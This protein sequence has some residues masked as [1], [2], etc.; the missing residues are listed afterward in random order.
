MFCVSRFHVRRMEG[1]DGLKELNSIKPMG[2]IM[3]EVEHNKGA[4]HKWYKKNTHTHT[5]KKVQC[6]QDCKRAQI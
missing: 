5:H 6:Y 1:F 4:Y 2:V 3:V